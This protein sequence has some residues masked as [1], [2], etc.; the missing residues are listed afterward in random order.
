[1]GSR[2][3]FIVL[4]VWLE[5]LLARGDYRRQ[6]SEQ[7]SGLA[8]EHVTGQASH[9]LHDGSDEQHDALMEQ[10]MR[11]PVAV[12]GG[13]GVPVAT[14]SAPAPSAPT[15][16]TDVGARADAPPASLAASLA[17]SQPSAWSRGLA[18][19]GGALCVLPLLLVGF[20]LAMIW[21]HTPHVP[22]WDEWET[23][24]LVQHATQGTLTWN[25]FWAFHN[26]HRIVLPRLL[27]LGLI[28]LTHWNRQIEMTFDLL[29]AVAECALLVV[30]AYRGLRAQ[31]RSQAHARALTALA[32]APMALAV[33]SLGQWE[34]W[35]W[36]FQITFILTVLGVALCVWGLTWTRSQRD[37]TGGSG[38]PDS[39]RIGWLAFGVA[40]IGAVVAAL[41]SLGGL[42]VFVAF[43]PAVFV[44]GYRKTLLWLVV[45]VGIIVPYLRG[46]PHST[47]FSLS[48]TTLKFVVAYL[49]A[50]AGT[51]SAK[52]AFA[53][54]VLSLALAVANVG[55]FWLRER[56]I[57]PLLPWI[58]LGGYAIGLALI[59][60]QG[61]LDLGLWSE[62][63]L[64]SRYQAFS[65]L[66]W[67]AVVYLLLLNARGAVAHRKALAHARWQEMSSVDA[68]LKPW[69]PWLFRANVALLMLA[70]VAL[71]MTSLASIPEMEAFQETQLQTEGCVVNVDYADVPCLWRFYPAP[72][73][74]QPL[75]AYLRDQRDT[76]FAGDY[77]R[78]EQ[79]TPSPAA[80]ALVR[81]YDPSDGDYL[82]TTRYDLNAYGPYYDPTVLGYVYD[83]QQ[84]GTHA[85]Y[86]CARA[87]GQHFVSLK[88]SCAGGT[89]SGTYVRTEGWLLTKPSTAAGSAAGASAETPLFDCRSAS[90]ADF[91]SSQ[92]T[93]ESQTGAGTSAGTDIGSLGYA[94]A[95]QP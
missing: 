82:V 21:T 59:T 33:F 48:L 54:G 72:N 31:V 46:F 85:L 14:L 77:Q 52:A 84:P 49:G 12:V 36:S 76:I 65:A 66:W 20:I 9:V 51:P 92:A 47:P 32:A 5:Q 64:T 95:A 90:A 57:T 40:V 26:E 62:I 30:S 86:S 68:H 25:D 83:Q 28:Q 91:V 35:L 58:G 4:Y 37:G 45:A 38:G 88:A 56:R 17:A 93:C 89:V 1:M 34:N 73:Q 43:L 71:L 15:A 11:R 55:Y 61:R 13:A 7:A 22:Y 50:P 8:L 39:E 75:V 41:S 94:L 87:D 23:V 78:L 44:Q 70:S 60:S 53:M 42:A 81:Y 80:H 10:T 24:T 16:P 29:L 19:L 3:L 6:A 2:Y 27:D 63:A 74:L 79:P 18:A 69:L 67:V